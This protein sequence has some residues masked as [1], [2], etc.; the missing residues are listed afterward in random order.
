MARAAG[1]KAR[2]CEFEVV[3]TRDIQSEIIEWFIENPGFG[4]FPEQVLRDYF[5]DR[6]VDLIVTFAIPTF[7][8]H[9][10]TGAEETLTHIL[11][12]SGTHQLPRQTIPGW[13][14]RMGGKL[15]SSKPNAA[16]LDE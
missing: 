13:I 5:I 3:L 14:Q 4:L 6:V 10:W 7:P 9:R 11:L 15:A 1:N 8:R 16:P 12:L 2:I